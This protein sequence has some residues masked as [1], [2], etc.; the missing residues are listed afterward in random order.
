MNQGVV[1]AQL[2]EA[3]TLAKAPASSDIIGGG[4]SNLTV[5]LTETVPTNDSLISQLSTSS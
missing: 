1:L 4:A 5:S 2:H 3:G